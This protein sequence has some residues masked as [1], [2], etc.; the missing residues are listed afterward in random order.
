MLKSRLTYH[1]T[2][3]LLI[4]MSLSLST[5]HFHESIEHQATPEAH[6]Q[7]ATTLDA[8]ATYCPICGYLFSAEVHTPGQWDIIFNSIDELAISGPA[9]H[10]SPTIYWSNNRSPPFLA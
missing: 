4:S 5:V 8:D 3:C 1:Y 9:P 6:T 7:T 10:T 2:F